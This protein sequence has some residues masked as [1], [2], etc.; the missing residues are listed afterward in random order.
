VKTSTFAWSHG[1]AEV[2]STAGMLSRC[3]FDLDGVEF[4]PFARAEWVGTG[5]TGH[6][7]HLRE[8]AAEFVCVPFGEGG[9][10]T[11][12]VAEWQGL[13]GSESNVPPHGPS[14]D[15]EWE[16]VELR[17]GGVTLRLDYP[18]G[19]PIESLE[20]RIDGV[21]GEPS[22]T[23]SL[24]ILARCNTSISVGLHPIVRLPEK[25]GA[26][27]L[28]AN[29][30]VGMAYPAELPPGA[31]RAKPGSRFDRL[32]EV[33]LRFGGVGDF[34]ILPFQEGAE[35]VLQLCG[36]SGPI[37]AEFIEEGA[38]IEIGWDRTALPSAQL[39]ISDRMLRDSPWNGRYRGLGVEP[40]AAA[41]DL[42]D[43]VSTSPNPI[44]RDG[45]ATAVVVKRGCPRTIDYRFRAI[46]HEK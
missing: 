35:E 41:F 19:H 15:E 4:E 25:P 27:R 7:G 44:N 21:P 38:S 30:D 46:S 12:V 32:A 3:V 8:L 34:G 20:R 2:L 33:P 18:D 9:P 40:I 43:A 16:V 36:G 23:L 22:L 1:W 10:A 13:I 29:F 14:A 11:G 17:E 6:L 39:W 42:A 5:V 37:V 31:S 45:Y 26:L 28:W 24:T